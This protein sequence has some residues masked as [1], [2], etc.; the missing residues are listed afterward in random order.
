MRITNLAERN[1]DTNS[2]VNYVKLQ[3]CAKY[4]GE[5]KVL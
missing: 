4:F 3:I 5:A 1:K 2:A